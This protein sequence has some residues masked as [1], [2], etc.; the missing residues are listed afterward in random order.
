MIIRTI[1]EI[2][3]GRKLHHVT[4]DTTAREA[5]AALADADVGALAVLQ[6]GVLIGVLS[7][8]DVIR[9]C[10]AGGKRTDDTR[11]SDIMTTNPVTVGAGARLA[12]ALA[13]MVKGHF[14]HLPVME[15]GTVVGMLSMRDIPTEYRLMFER[16]TE[17]QESPTA[18]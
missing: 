5:C 6:N 17:Y 8:R 10:V 11:V 14:R 1:S 2:L 12:D 13:A 16:F 4:P 9:K 15:N 7:E 3:N 18:A